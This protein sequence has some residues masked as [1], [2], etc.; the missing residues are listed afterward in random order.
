MI[1]PED[2]QP[3]MIRPRSSNSVARTQSWGSIRGHHQQPDQGM[4][5]ISPPS[6]PTNGE[7]DKI[8]NMN[9]GICPMEQSV[10]KP[11]LLDPSS[12]QLNGF[13]RKSFTGIPYRGG[14]I[15]DAGVSNTLDRER[16]MGDA[17]GT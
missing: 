7:D 3:I 8:T 16:D 4:P 1:R 6:Y 17:V 12:A 10:S 14:S 9:R 11:I 5:I 2:D 13:R 15:S